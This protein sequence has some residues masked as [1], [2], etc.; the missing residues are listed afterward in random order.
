MFLLYL[1]TH[2]SMQ[3]QFSTGWIHPEVTLLAINLGSKSHISSFEENF[4]WGGV[5]HPP[6]PLGNF[7][8]SFLYFLLLPPLT[9]ILA[10]T[11]LLPFLLACLFLLTCFTWLRG[12][13]IPCYPAY[14][15]TFLLCLLSHLL[16]E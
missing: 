12:Y 16:A 2:E 11:Y 3:I 4:F 5:P 14:S 15:L 10:Y 8:Q 13:W 7:P 6:T 9:Y 1:R